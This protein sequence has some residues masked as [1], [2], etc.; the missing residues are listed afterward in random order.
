MG[1]VG[2]RWT[3]ERERGK[4]EVGLGSMKSGK[5]DEFV[6]VCVCVWREKG[7]GGEWRSLEQNLSLELV[8]TKDPICSARCRKSGMSGGAA[9]TQQRRS[10]NPPGGS[11][12]GASGKPFLR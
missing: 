5:R 3:R 4:E 12:R 6:P 7:G 10:F 11:E 1:G 8:M 2:E 9:L